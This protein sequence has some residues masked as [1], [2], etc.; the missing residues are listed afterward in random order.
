MAEQ[1]YGMVLFR[2]KGSSFNP[3]LQLW[4][5]QV[6]YVKGKLESVYSEKKT[7]PQKVD[8]NK[9]HLGDFIID[10]IERM[11]KI[12]NTIAKLK[13]IDGGSE[14][15]PDESSGGSSKKSSS[16]FFN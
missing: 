2:D 9:A 15:L 10:G 3:A 4:F 12:R 8:I 11:R 14:S 1:M 6:Q 13:T 5:T 16:S 7:Q